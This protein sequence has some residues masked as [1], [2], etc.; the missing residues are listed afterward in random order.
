MVPEVAPGI[1]QIHTKSN[2]EKTVGFSKIGFR[3]HL[4][5]GAATRSVV[6]PGITQIHTKTNVGKTFG[7]LKFVLACI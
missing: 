4:S 3:V 7:F 5:H 6:T 1:A 2:F